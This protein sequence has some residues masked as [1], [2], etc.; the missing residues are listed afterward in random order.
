MLGLALEGATMVAAARV[1]D[2]MH[3]LD[4]A[5]AAAVEGD[6]TILILSAST[7]C[8]PVSAGTPRE[9]EVLGL[10]AEDMTN[11]E[12][13][14]ALVV[15]ESAVHRRVT[16]ILRKARASLPDGGGPTLCTGHA[17]RLSGPGHATWPRAR[18][19]KLSVCE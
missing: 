12:I 10:L 3:C 8:F 9:S 6:A 19:A 1:D 2:H 5:T 7:F 4:E 11:L 18:P 15:S 14:D 13:T 16:N 17:R